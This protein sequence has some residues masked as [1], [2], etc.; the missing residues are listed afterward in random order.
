MEEEIQLL[1]TA[2]K[3]DIDTNGK[4]IIFSDQKIYCRIRYGYYSENGGY[5]Y[6]YAFITEDYVNTVAALK[7]LGLEEFMEGMSPETVAYVEIDC[8]L[9]AS[10]FDETDD[11]LEVMGEKFGVDMSGETLSYDS[12]KYADLAESLYG[13]SGNG[14][15][16]LWLDIT[17]PEEIEEL[18]SLCDYYSYPSYP[19]RNQLF[20]SYPDVDVYVVM[21]DGSGYTFTIPYG[22]MPKEYILRLAAQL[23]KEE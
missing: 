1:L 15:A 22:K 17:D 14:Y 16:T 5:Y 3:E 6:N 2:L 8:N 21:K 23:E 9:Y 4:Q 10:D 18:L 12:E 11:I 13:E 20:C 7:K 19:S